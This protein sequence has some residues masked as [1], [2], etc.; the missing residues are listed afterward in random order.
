MFGNLS[1]AIQALAMRMLIS[2]LVDEILVPKY[3]N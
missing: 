2:F 3:M 1:L